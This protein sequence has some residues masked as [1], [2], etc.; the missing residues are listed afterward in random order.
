VAGDGLASWD[1]ISPDAGGAA[2]DIVF[3]DVDW[4][5]INSNLLFKE[6]RA[7]PTVSRFAPDA[8]FYRGAVVQMSRVK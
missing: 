2:S 1:I 4:S 6:K 3:S 5:L 8:M 7:I